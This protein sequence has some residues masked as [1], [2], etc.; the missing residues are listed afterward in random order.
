MLAPSLCGDV[1][2]EQQGSA[3]VA[4]LSSLVNLQSPLDHKES[5]LIGVRAATHGGLGMLLGSW[6]LA[7]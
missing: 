3:V 2:V 1:G 4:T 6:H 7:L 5:S